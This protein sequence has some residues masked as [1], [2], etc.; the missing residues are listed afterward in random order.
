MKFPR[1]GLTVL[2]AALMLPL[3][4]PLLGQAQVVA[5]C[6]KKGAAGDDDSG[7]VRPDLNPKV[8]DIN[9]GIGPKV[10]TTADIVSCLNGVVT[11][12]GGQVL[13][14]ETFLPIQS[15]VLGT[16]FYCNKCQNIITITFTKPLQAYSFLLYNGGTSR[17]EVAVTDDEGTR[18]FSLEPISFSPRGKF[19]QGGGDSRN[20]TFIRVGSAYPF[21]NFSIAGLA[22]VFK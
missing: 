11:F 3:I 12:T 18:R 6:T 15:T 9:F 13:K 14:Q 5:Q 22:I 7:I 17:T 8:I 19:L 21:W 2:C 20:I 1:I 4:S 16:S 10:F